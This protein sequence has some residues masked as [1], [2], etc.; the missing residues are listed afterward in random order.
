[1]EF[2]FLG[3]A[4]GLLAL[5]APGALGW[6]GVLNG[7]GFVAIL[8]VYWFSIALSLSSRP[9][10]DVPLLILVSVLAV[11]VKLSAAPLFFLALV[12][13]WFHRKTADLSLVKPA[14]V[15]AVLLVL[16]MARSVALSGCLVYPLPQSCIPGLPWAVE[17]SHAVTE[18]LGIK[19]WARAP[20][21]F[22]PAKVLSDWTWV[23]QWSL[24]TWKDW[25]ARLFVAGA[26]AGFVSVLVGMR[27]DR[28][29]AG[30][31]A[32]LGL[33]L[34]Y[35]FWN[36]PDVRFGFGYLAA[37]G[38]L[39]FAIACTAYFPDTDLARRLTLDAV[40]VSVLLGAAGLLHSGNTWTVRNP[41]AVAMR[42]TP[43]G[44]SIGVTQGNREGS[45]Q[46][47]DHPLPCSPYFEP[48]RLKHVRWR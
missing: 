29:V 43:E 28:R 34:A 26:L 37:A 21:R 3:L 4:V 5:G 8:T 16:W 20:H 17:R 30:A 9:Q 18:M 1:V 13:A 33:C 40:A 2:W 41:P 48:E 35:W 47:W 36:A 27:I 25:S 10:T 6:L 38:I 42:T 39:G 7:D 44:K 15:A 23:G 32:G 22:D 14:A 31:M 24:N 19:S 12:V 46:C 45:D 11:T